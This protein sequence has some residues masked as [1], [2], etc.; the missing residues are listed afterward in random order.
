MASLSKR[1]KNYYSCIRVRVGSRVDG[2][3]KVTYIKLHTIKKSSAKIR[4]AIVT[5]EE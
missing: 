5:R 4:N 3:K 2:K 1:G